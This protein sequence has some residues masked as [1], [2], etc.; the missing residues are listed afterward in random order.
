MKWKAKTLANPSF[1]D[2]VVQKQFAFLPTRVG[3][4]WVLWEYYYEVFVFRR[5]RNGV[6]GEWRTTDPHPTRAMSKEALLLK[7]K[8]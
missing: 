8:E 1:G 4:H 3:E 2:K 5:G 7:E 6:Y